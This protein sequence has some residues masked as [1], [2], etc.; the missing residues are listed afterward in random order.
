MRTITPDDAP[1]VLDLAVSSG[2]FGADDADVVRTML[3]DYFEGNRARG[4]VCVL[5]DGNGTEGDGA[6][7]DSTEDDGPAG[8]A[9]YQPAVATDRTWYLT[10]I[11]VGADRQ[12]QGRGSALLRAVEDD[13]RARGQ[14]LLLVETSGA[15]GFARTRAFY[16]RCG[17]Q[18][19]ARV[20]DYY[21]AGDDLVLFGKPLPA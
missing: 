11:A 21:E 10:M 16:Q 6:E 4:H 9:Y 5:D 13:L 20:G 17:Y 1:S 18:Q 15:P 7:R 19:Q 8:V 14:R 3:A 12:G 2:L